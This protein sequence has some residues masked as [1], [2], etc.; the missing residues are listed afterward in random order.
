MEGA[1][2]ACVPAG[3]DPSHRRD[4]LSAYWRTAAFTAA[5]DLDLF[6]VLGRGARTAAELARALHADA[7]A[8]RTLC[9]ALVSMGFLH[10]S[11]GRYCRTSRAVRFPEAPSAGALAAL[12]R[13]FKA[14]PVKRAFASLSET[15]RRGPSAEG[16]ASR[17]GVWTSFAE[18]TSALR[19]QLADDIADCLVG[20]RLVGGR[21]LDI[22]AGGS[23]LGIALLRRAR[24][25]SLIAQDRAAVV[26]V[27]RRRAAAA[28]VGDRLVTLPGDALTVDWGGPFDLVLMVNVLDYLAGADRARLLRKARAALRPGGCLVVAAPLL[29]D[30]RQSPPDAVAYALMLLALQSPGQPSTTR[31]LRQWLRRARFATIIRCS[32]PSMMLARR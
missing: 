16:A 5:V 28:G 4:P 15:V 14:P 17:V 22:G 1:I 21:I 2:V 24:T 26:A 30:S 12:P 18:Q 6:R 19:Q 8:V 10:S 3:F 9:D 7:A 13:F 32:S 23:P 27:A 29:D 25:A 11:R 31:E 20:R